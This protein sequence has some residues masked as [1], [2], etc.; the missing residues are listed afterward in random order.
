MSDMYIAD[1]SLEAHLTAPQSAKVLKVTLRDSDDF[2]ETTFSCDLFGYET[3]EQFQWQ[4]AP[5][6]TSRKAVLIQIAMDLVERTGK[7]GALNWA[8]NVDLAQQIEE[9]QLSW[10]R[11]AFGSALRAYGV[12]KRLTFEQALHVLE[13]HYVVEPIMEG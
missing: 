2:H 7:D 3:V 6:S 12:T 4:P 10:K 8:T 13:E 11:K 9:F 1:V 5:R